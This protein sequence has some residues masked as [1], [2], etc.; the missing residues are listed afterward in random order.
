[1]KRYA[2]REF[3]LLCAPLALIGASFWVVRALHPPPDPDALIRLGVTPAPVTQLSP[4]QFY[5][6]WT[7]VATGGPKNDATLGYA[8]KLVAT[9]HGH[10]RTILSDPPAAAPAKPTASVRWISPGL[11]KSQSYLT[12]N[13]SVPYRELPIWTERVQWQGE[14]VAIPR[15]AATRATSA[16]ALPVATL[17]SWAQI[18]GAARAAK[19]FPVS[20]DAKQLA[21][22]GKCEPGTISRFNAGL[23]ADTCAKIDLRDLDHRVFKRLIAFDGTKQRELWRNGASEAKGVYASQETSNSEGRSVNLQLWKLRDVP[24]QW[25]E[26]VYLVDVVFDPNGSKSGEKSCDAR[27]IAR[28]TGAGWFHASCRLMVRAKGAI[29]SGRGGSS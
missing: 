4:S 20:V 3:A 9:G 16:G 22:L 29:W 13:W 15:D 7:A 19:G 6:A 8:Q 1:M 18:K 27:E 12:F 11:A 28:L 10:S 17:Q 24:A 5:F 23:G 25:G 26:I 14:V 2:L 21:P